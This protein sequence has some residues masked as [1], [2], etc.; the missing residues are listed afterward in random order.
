[1]SY[2]VLNIGNGRTVVTG[3]KAKEYLSKVHIL[4]DEIFDE[5]YEVGKTKRRRYVYDL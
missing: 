2:I 1:L 3:E 4:V 5:I